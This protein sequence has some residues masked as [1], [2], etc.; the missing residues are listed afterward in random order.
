MTIQIRDTL[1]Q[2]IENIGK[3]DRF[4]FI[5][6]DPCRSS[7]HFTDVVQDYI[8]PKPYAN[9]FRQDTDNVYGVLT[10]YYNTLREKE[11]IHE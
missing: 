11:G 4:V 8:L 3:T 7:N 6:Y 2:L 9:S 10:N 5:K 1:E